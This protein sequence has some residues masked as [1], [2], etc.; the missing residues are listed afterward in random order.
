M[1]FASVE[2]RYK[3]RS[4]DASLPDEILQRIKSIQ[5][6]LEDAL[7]KGLQSGLE[8]KKASKKASKG[9]E[10]ADVIE[11]EDEEVR[12]MRE[13]T[14]ALVSRLPM[15]RIQRV[16]RAAA[17]ASELHGASPCISA[18]HV[19]IQV[20]ESVCFI[21]KSLCPLNGLCGDSINLF[22]V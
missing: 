4:L 8:L 16:L 9:E 6:Q 12:A 18:S 13:K 17:G 15:Q 22:R 1:A 11:D 19:R 20:F 10:A 21:V 7:Q 2:P 5:R 3:L 14:K